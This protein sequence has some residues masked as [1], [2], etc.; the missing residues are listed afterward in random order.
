MIKLILAEIKKIP[1]IKDIYIS[2]LQTYYYDGG[3]Y[4]KSKLPKFLYPPFLYIQDL[5]ECFMSDLI[6]LDTLSL[7]KFFHDK[8]NIPIRKFRKIIVGAQDDIF[9]PIKHIITNNYRY[10]VGFWSTYIPLQGVKYINEAANMLKQNDDI[11]S[12]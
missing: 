11:I 12:Y 2:K 7:I 10:W 4:E 1:L 9:Q 3:L 6:I 5:I 8:Y